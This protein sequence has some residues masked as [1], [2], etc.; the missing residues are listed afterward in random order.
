MIVNTNIASLNAQRSLTGTNNAMQ[1]S[2]EKLS[3][4]SRINKAADDA[5]GLAISEKMRGQIKGLSQAVRNAQSAISL[6][7]TGEGALNETHSILQR[8]RE[9]AVQS[10]SDTNTADDR[11]KI[12]AEMDQLA[13]EISRISNTTEFNTQNL[14]AGGLNDT[15][16]IGANAGQNISL[17]VNAMDA[18]SLG[19]AGALVDTTF[20]N[21][22]TAVTS[23]AT[24]S[25]NV[26]GYYVSATKTATAASAV[27]QSNALGGAGTAGVGSYTGSSDTTFKVKITGTNDE[28][29][30]VMEVTSAAYSTD[31][32]TTW[33]NASVDSSG[34]GSSTITLANGATLA[35]ASDAQNAVDDT[36]TY[37]ASAEYLS[38]QLNSAANGGGTRIGS[39]VKAYNNES[40]VQIGSSTTN[41]AVTVNFAFA[42]V[43]AAIA[44]AGTY[45]G[46]QITQTS[47]SST[48]A[49]I[50]AN[51]TVT[52][53][54]VA[55]K[56]VDVTTQANAN[57]S[58][59][60]IDNAI[61]TVS[62]ER[63]KLGAMQNRL[64]HTI[65][66]LQA[67]SENLTSAESS[68]RD[69]DMAAEMS[70]FTKN[71][72][73]SQAGVAMLAQ[74]NQVPQAVLKL[75]G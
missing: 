70:T 41:Q 18:Q 51:G 67:A 48:A 23:I 3:S 31:G 50:G 32:G 66:N 38:F 54:A 33:I 19:V 56:G 28:G 57:L 68:I 75:L 11:T 17:T 24:T 25:S 58:I 20:T 1:K 49:T 29:A 74:A 22:N 64:E 10:A 21:T 16:H 53:D 27:T 42:T 26:S 12:Q 14:L 2:L 45:E 15:F 40:S 5:A 46:D 35:V 71:Q 65:N 62:Q 73:L 60:T 6:I 30:G 13:K 63:S 44:V 4:G 47:T 55:Y 37:T 52:T 39:I 8:M 59:T 61:K 72:I 69:V 36:Y 7:Q 43:K 9:L 34:A